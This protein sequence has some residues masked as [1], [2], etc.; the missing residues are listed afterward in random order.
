[1][2]AQKLNRVLLFNAS[3]SILCA[4]D[5]LIFSQLIADYMGGFAPIYLQVIALGLIGFAIFVFWVSRQ[6]NNRQLALS[7][8]QMDRSWVVGSILML[9]FANSWFSSAGLLIIGT[10]AVIVAGFG[11]KQ[12]AYIKQLDQQQSSVA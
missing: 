6:K 4:I 8:V 2:V 9:V 7:I 10:V 5:M 11:E 3:F 1:M 12:N